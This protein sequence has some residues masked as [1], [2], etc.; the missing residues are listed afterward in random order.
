MHI[1]FITAKHIGDTV[2]STSILEHMH[3]KYPHAQ[4][5]VVCG[6][7]PAPILQA[8]YIKN[9]IPIKKRSYRFHWFDI[10][11]SCYKK[12]WDIIVDLR[13]SFLSYFLYTKKRLIWKPQNSSKHKLEQLASFMETTSLPLPKIYPS[14]EA[15][16]KADFFLQGLKNPVVLGATASWHAKRWENHKFSLL[17]QYLKKNVFKNNSF[18]V[19]GASGDENFANE[20]C[21]IVPKDLIVPIVGKMDLL[22]TAAFLKKSRIF[23]GND[24]GLMHISAAVGIPTLGL[25]GP[26][27]ESVYSPVGKYTHWVRTDK[28]Y[29]D[30]IENSSYDWK[31]PDNMMKTLSVEKVIEAIDIL[32]EK[33]KNNA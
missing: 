28:S 15:Q 1:L 20:L 31:N 10:W 6:E 25:F 17:V 4:V 13:G 22:T 33:V 30:L 32:E 27:R 21:N 8:P 26:S 3:K 14:K 16:K 18:V 5:T 24:S 29:E 11:Q 12:K 19:L 7:R 2:L 9:V 23:I